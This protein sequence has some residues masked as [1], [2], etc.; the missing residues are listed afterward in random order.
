M[1]ADS[2]PADPGPIEL[3]TSPDPLE[4][5][6]LLP[7]L[8]RRWEIP[9]VVK[10]DSEFRIEE[11]GVMAD[12]TPLFAVYRRERPEPSDT[13][14]DVP[15]VLSFE[16]GRLTVRARLLPIAGE[17]LM[18]V[19]VLGDS[20]EDSSALVRVRDHFAQSAHRARERA[21]GPHEPKAQR[22]EGAQ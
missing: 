6:V 22:P 14:F 11:A 16:H 5:F 2:H 20:P 13:E 12:Q 1:T 21:G 18:A 4:D 15:V 9:Q 7:G 8:L 3:D 19:V 10:A 17:P